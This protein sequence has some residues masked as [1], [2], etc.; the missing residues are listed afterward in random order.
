M[1]SLQ[2]DSPLLSDLGQE[3]GGRNGDIL[4]F[5]LAVGWV[6]S[7]V[8]EGGGF[9]LHALGNSRWDRRNERLELGNESWD[10]GDHR[11]PHERGNDFAVLVSQNISLRNDFLPRDL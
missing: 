5:Y 11:L 9:V 10:M 6:G 2:R 7:G 8:T 4:N 1:R 3:T